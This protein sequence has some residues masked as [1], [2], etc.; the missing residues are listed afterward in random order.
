MVWAFTILITDFSGLM[1]IELTTEKTLTSADIRLDR[2][3]HE[4]FPRIPLM[5]AITFVQFLMHFVNQQLID[6][7]VMSS[8]GVPNHLYICS[9][10]EIKFHYPVYLFIQINQFNY[11]CSHEMKKE[12]KSYFNLMPLPFYSN[13]LYKSLFCEEFE[14]SNNEGDSDFKHPI[15][16]EAFLCSINCRFILFSILIMYHYISWKL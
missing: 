15:F 6:Y 14:R 3:R 13:H 7:R 12:S 10:K 8:F 4:A 1:L 16:A 9:L 2:Q 11:F 5:S